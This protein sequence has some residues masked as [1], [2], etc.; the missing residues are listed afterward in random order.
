MV[1]DPQVDRDVV[2]AAVPA[3]SR[4]TRSA[5]DC[6]PRRS[7]PAS[8][9]AVA[10]RAAGGPAVCRPESSPA[11]CIAARP[12]AREHVALDGEAVPGQAARPVQARRPGVAGGSA[13]AVHDPHLPVVAA[14][15]VLDQPLHGDR[16]GG[17][18]VEVGEGQALV[19]TFAS[20]WVA[21]APTWATAAGTAAPTAR[22]LEAT[23]TP[24]DSP[25]ADR[26]TME[27]VMDGPCRSQQ[28]AEG[29]RSMLRSSG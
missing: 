7:P 23:A 9:P 5:A 6:R 17:A 21:I 28:A 14:G 18:V 16:G 8:S 3:S 24:H 15:V 22:N 10:R 20:A 26:A 1:V 19:A 27:K 12:L 2:E 11:A 25:S 4:T 29:P 13:V